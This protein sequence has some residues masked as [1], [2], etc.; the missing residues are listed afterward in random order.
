LTGPFKGLSQHESASDV[1]TVITELLN[2][3]EST[4]K[5]NLVANKHSITSR[6][7][8]DLKRREMDTPGVLNEIKEYSKIDTHAETCYDEILSNNSTFHERSDVTDNY[9]SSLYSSMFSEDVA[10]N[11]YDV[12][13]MD[14]N[15]EVKDL[16]SNNDEIKQNVDAAKCP[17]LFRKARMIGIDIGTD[18]RSNN[19]S[20][21]FRRHGN[22]EILHGFEQINDNLFARKDNRFL[23]FNDA[24]LSDWPP[25]SKTRLGGIIEDVNLVRSAIEN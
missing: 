24:G 22:N 4:E 5:K 10:S 21:S 16:A 18:L 11:D 17:Q 20:N 3:L 7:V 14:G 25:E 23:V 13:S 6:V 8:E 15:L 2:R 1:V 9:S 19:T 12:S